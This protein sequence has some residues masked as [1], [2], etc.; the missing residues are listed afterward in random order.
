MDFLGMILVLGGVT[1]LLL[2]TQWG[3]NTLPWSSSTVIGLLVGFGLLAIAYIALEI[4]LKERAAL[5][6]RLLKNKTI[7]L[8]MAY[9]IFLS[10]T[11]F[12]LLYYVPIYFQSV[13]GVSA[14]QSGIRT[15]P[16]IIPVALF[17]IASGIYITVTGE[18]QAVMIVAASFTAIG[19][20]LVYTFHPSSSSGMWIG[21]QVICGIGQGLGLQIPLIV[22]QAVVDREDLS[23]ISAMAIFFQLLGGAVWISVAQSIFQN[24]LI[25]YLNANLTGVTTKQVLSAGATGLDKLLSPEQLRIIADG[26]MAGVKGAF[27]LCVALACMSAG[28]AI[29]TLVMDRRKLT[30]AVFGKKAEEVDT[31]SVALATEG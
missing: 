14:S 17:A 9:Q 6:T 12:V 5:P 16:L 25:E 27:G 31:G 22:A 18:Y 26:Y 21:Y 4:Y 2:A 19:C 8:L 11:F 15:I 24:R 1:C 28:F 30:P 7:A 10:G 13:K 23:I 29:L 3:G 20:G